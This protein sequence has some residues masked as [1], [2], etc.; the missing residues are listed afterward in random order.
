MSELILQ[1]EQLN[2]SG[3]HDLLAYLQKLLSKKSKRQVPFDMDAYRKS[4]LSIS[5]WSEEELAGFEEV[6]AHFNEWK[7]REW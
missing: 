5:V 4:I 7:P 1:F 3:R 2:D 6:K